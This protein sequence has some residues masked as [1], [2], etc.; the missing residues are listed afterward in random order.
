MSAAAH[1]ASDAVRKGVAAALIDDSGLAQTLGGPKVFDHPPDRLRPPYIVIG[2]TVASDW[3]TS[4]DEGE[5]VV[6]FLHVWT[7][8]EQRDRNHAAQADV[9]RALTTEPE[10]DGHHLVALR[11]ELS[12]TR[13]DPSTG[14]V[15]AVMR[16]RAVTEAL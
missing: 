2:R 5:A 9:R 1:T 3:S 8:G 15:H 12:E 13:R 7:K 16:F 14:H 10:L 4:G 11:H 6:L